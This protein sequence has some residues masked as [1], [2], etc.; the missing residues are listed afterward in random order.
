MK[1]NEKNQRPQGVFVVEGKG[2]KAFW[3]RIGAAWPHDDGKGFNL[4]L[5]CMPLDGRPIVREPKGD[6]ETAR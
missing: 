3:T 1:C 2:D 4:Q 6:K 5:S